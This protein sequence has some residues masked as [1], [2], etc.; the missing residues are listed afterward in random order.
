MYPKLLS[1]YLYH[2]IVKCAM[3]KLHTGASTLLR[4]KRRTNQATSLGARI[5]ND[6]AAVSHHLIFRPT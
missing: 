1:M 2:L 3:N 4:E 6:L 5:A